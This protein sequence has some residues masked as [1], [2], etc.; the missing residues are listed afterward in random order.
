[1]AWVDAMF[2][3]IK[4]GDQDHQNWLQEKLKS[5]V[6]SNPPPLQ[7]AQRP[8]VGLTDEEIENQVSYSCTLEDMVRSVE[9]KLREQNT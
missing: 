2:D 4:H 3:V 7:P 1:M 9:A 5:W 8:W 6:I